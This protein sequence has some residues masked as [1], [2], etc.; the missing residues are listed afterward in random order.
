MKE[1]EI[2]KLYV[3]RVRLAHLTM[4][5]TSAVI[6]IALSADVF[7]HKQLLLELEVIEQLSEAIGIPDE[8]LVESVTQS[9]QRQVDR[10]TIDR[11]Y[12][13]A[14]LI[15]E[16]NRIAV[17]RDHFENTI[18]FN[19]VYEIGWYEWLGYFIEPLREADTQFEDFF[20]T[21]SEGVYSAQT[22]LS[23]WDDMAEVR[24]FRL[25][26]GIKKEKVYAYKS[27]EGVYYPERSCAP[28]PIQEMDYA[29]LPGQQVLKFL[30]PDTSY[31]LEI[32]VYIDQYCEYRYEGVLN[33]IVIAFEPMRFKTEV[34]QV[35]A[36]PSKRVLSTYEQIESM[37]NKLIY[38]V[39][40]EFEEVGVDM[41]QLLLDGE[42]NLD[43]PEIKAIIA[44]DFKHT[45]RFFES[46][47]EIDFSGV[48]FEGMKKAISRTDSFEN[49]TV[50]ILGMQSSKSSIVS[51]GGI[52]VFSSLIYFAIHLRKLKELISEKSDDKHLP[53]IGLY[54]DIHSKIILV[55]SSLLLPLA[56]GGLSLYYLF[57]ES[58]NDLADSLIIILN[59]GFLVW[60]VGIAIHS[61]FLV[62][63]TLFKES[64]ITQNE[65]NSID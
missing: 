59:I 48:P 65:K 57:D 63:A 49:G 33:N 35:G 32:D 3:E 22:F 12:E 46:Y 39:Y 19:D 21:D 5:L 53:W 24:K 23:I 10:N 1:F 38:Q 9:I 30:Q 64:T 27:S 6:L 28:P 34:I 7:R 16:D 13:F 51:W 60:G 29:S 20:Y 44:S 4:I 31:S 37:R 11:A 18:Y 8:F 54:D 40:P 50:N 45:R 55:T 62:E 41:R 56:A 47:E 61:I 42:L 25:I 26:T 36:G 52:M 14:Y 15:R 58:V 2:E 17:Q 43:D